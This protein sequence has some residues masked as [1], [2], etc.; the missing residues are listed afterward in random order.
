MLPFIMIGAFITTL[1]VIGITPASAQFPFAVY[2]KWMA[3]GVPNLLIRGDR[4]IGAGGGP[5]EVTREIR[6]N[7]AKPY[8]FLRTRQEGQT[9]DN[10][11]STFGGN[12]LQFRHPELVTRVQA[13][14]KMT[15][16]F[17]DS[18]CPANANRTTEPQAEIFWEGF[19][20]GSSTG[21]GDR[22]GDHRFDIRA[23]R[24]ANTLDPPGILQ[25]RAAVCR[26]STPSCNNQTCSGTQL[27]S[28]ATPKFTLQI[29]HDPAG[30][31]NAKALVSVVGGVQQTFGYPSTTPPNP[32]QNPA[33]NKFGYLNAGGTTANCMVASGGPKEFDLEL[34]ILKVLTNPEAVIP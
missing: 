13:T 5:Q 14:F 25:V 19:N 3:A 32:Q 10:T 26:C 18:H 24:L 34:Q 27:P 9:T 21:P 12:G 2:E 4:W 11:G 8:L 7:G 15:K 33:V 28:I 29:I 17:I 20:D 30:A 22:T 23:S 6:F 16:L 31:S 1:A